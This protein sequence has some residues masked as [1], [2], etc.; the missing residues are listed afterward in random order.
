[1]LSPTKRV[2]NTALTLDSC[3]CLP[4]HGSACAQ[5]LRV[6]YNSG[7][8]A[9][10]RDRNSTHASAHTQVNTATLRAA[11]RR[12]KA[13][14]QPEPS[15]PAAPCGSLLT[16]M[17]TPDEPQGGHSAL[18]GNRA[19]GQP[20]HAKSAH[21]SGEGSGRASSH[22]TNGQA[23]IGAR[24][25]SCMENRALE[26]TEGEG[27]DGV[28]A[29]VTHGEVM[30]ALGDYAG[31][32]KH[33][34][35]ALAVLAPRSPRSEGLDE[36]PLQPQAPIGIADGCK[37]HPEELQVHKGRPMQSSELDLG[38]EGG[39]VGGEAEGERV[40]RVTSGGMPGER[41]EG[42]VSKAAARVLLRRAVCHKHLGRY[43]Q[44]TPL[45]CGPQDFLS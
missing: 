45:Q 31:A 1:M 20:A 15:H 14:L 36:S 25:C 17:A 38:S 34:S 30:M 41:S 2:G 9:H 4:M 24:E 13:S 16:H 33:F 43:R 23:T 28:S 35:R 6:A 27:G 10:V 3:V 37:A 44:V 12:L 32:E 39:S 29:H 8:D 5:S 42:R 40:E 11:T 19:D 7:I 21:T 22:V 18:L 26:G